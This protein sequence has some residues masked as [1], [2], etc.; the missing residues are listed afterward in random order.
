MGRD[1]QA[2]VFRNKLIVSCQDSAQWNIRMALQGGCGGLRL[3]GPRDVKMARLLSLDI[4]IVACWKMHVSGYSVYITPNANQVQGLAD[5]GADII[6]FDATIRTR[7]TEVSVMVDTIH[8]AGLMAMADIRNVNEGL[9]ASKVGADFIST[10]LNPKM[11][12]AMLHQLAD[13]TDKTIVEEG[14]IWSPEEAK[15]AL[16]YGADMVVIGTAITRPHEITR[17]Y[18]EAL[19]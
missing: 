17:R 19:K 5:A 11:D 18:V 14:G 8:R 15:L 7:P 1:K 12:G 2:V 6:A 16:K 10:T 4:P 3:N 13:S 9:E